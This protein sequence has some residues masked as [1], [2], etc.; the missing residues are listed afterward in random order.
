MAVV[1]AGA[2]LVG[3]LTPV[4]AATGARG[5]RPAV[6]GA[7]VAVAGPEPVAEAAGRADRAALDAAVRAMVSPGGSTAALGLVVERGR[8]V[9]KGAAGTADLATGTP[10]SPDGQFRIGSVTKTFVA[11]VVLQLVAEHRVGLDDPVER[12]LPGLVPNGGQITVRQLLGHT[13]GI[14]NYTEDAS[15]AFEESEGTLQQWLAT[16]RW[17]SYQPRELVAL[18]TSH[19]VY[20]APGKGWHY[21]NTN[22]IIAGM[23]I[24]RLTGRSWAQEVE[25]RIIRPLGLSGTSMPIDSPFVPGPHAHG[26]YKLA[27]GPADT[28]L[29]NP[30]M[31]GSAGAGISTTADLTR[32]ISA[33]LGGRLLGPA[34]L[35]EM[36][37]VSPESGQAYGLGLQRTPTA[38]G[39]FW[40]HGGGIPGYITLLYGA[41]DGR[42]QFAGSVNA[43]DLSDPAATDTAFENLVATGVCGGRPPAA[44]VPAV[45]PVAPEGVRAGTGPLA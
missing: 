42:R 14:F 12:H 25:R 36:K 31:A 22:Y 43:Y 41:A 8:P 3:A 33:L 13:S 37:R 17:R 28:T 30:S 32:F 29:L 9:W 34:E 18:A 26:Y 16:G 1:L 24:E 10:A 38:C 23:L 15:F 4:A 7:A 27:D 35:A 11:T 39:E 40:G 20:F 2:G 6:D 45:P 5:A 44:P 19:P 21:S